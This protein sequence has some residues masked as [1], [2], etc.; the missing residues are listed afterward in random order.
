MTPR[1]HDADEVR[2]R[3]A[4][5]AMLRHQGDITD[6]RVLAALNDVPR[7]RFVP[8]EARGRAYADTA[9][10]IGLGQTIS[11]PYVVG[12]MSQALH[13]HPRMRVL[14]V[15]TGSGYQ[16]AVLARLCASVVTLECVPEL[17]LRAREHFRALG[18]TNVLQL[19]GDGAEGYPPLAPYGGIMVTAAAWDVPAPLF[20]QLAPGG[21]LVAPVGPQDGQTLRCWTLREDGKLE[22]EDL[23]PCRFVPLQGPYGR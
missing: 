11:Q 16:C 4:L 12:M 20:D 21:R 8:E 23:F 7:H 5:V 18:L 10:P 2:A 9:L 17:A 19:L 3:H 1:H 22:E 14:E 6:P 15:G 13:T